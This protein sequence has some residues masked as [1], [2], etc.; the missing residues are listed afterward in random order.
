[1]NKTLSSAL[2]A[3]MF[4]FSAQA[5]QFD[6]KDISAALGLSETVDVRGADNVP[7]VDDAGTGDDNKGTT[8]PFTGSDDADAKGAAASDSQGVATGDVR[9]E[10]FAEFDY[11]LHADT[12]LSDRTHTHRMAYYESLARDV[13]IAMVE[14][15]D[16]DRASQYLGI[17]VEVFT[18]P[19]WQIVGEHAIV[20]LF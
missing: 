2:A 15:V 9:S 14:N 11:S 13:A 3:A 5:V 1:M 16:A 18:D 12:F 19:D 10:L 7:T 20:D 17:P 4:A 6:F 8:A